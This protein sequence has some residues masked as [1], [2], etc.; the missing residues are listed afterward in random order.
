MNRVDVEIRL[1]WKVNRDHVKQLLTR[2]T[3]VEILL[4]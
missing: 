2:G 4:F 3:A 1:P